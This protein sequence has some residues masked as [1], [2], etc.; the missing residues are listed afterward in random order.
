MVIKLTNA[1]FRITLKD[2]KSVMKEYHNFST[3]ENN[4]YLHFC[5][6]YAGLFSP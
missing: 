5:V 2:K 1:H 6:F 3:P 4:H